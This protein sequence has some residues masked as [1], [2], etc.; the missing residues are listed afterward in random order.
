MIYCGKRRP[1]DLLKLLGLVTFRCGEHLEKVQGKFIY[2]N[3][4]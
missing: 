4:V 1:D 3:E 2:D